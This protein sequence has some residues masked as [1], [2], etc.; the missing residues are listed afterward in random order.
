MK[1]AERTSRVKS[2]VKDILGNVPPYERMERLALL[3][4]IVI[5][6]LGEGTEKGLETFNQKI[7]SAMRD[8]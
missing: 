2:A 3:A 8:L 4:V 6:D 7:L 1:D 5:R